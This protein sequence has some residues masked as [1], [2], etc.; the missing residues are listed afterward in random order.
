[1][2]TELKTIRILE[3]NGNVSN[4]DAWNEKFGAKAKKRGYK[5]KKLLLGKETV[6]T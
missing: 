4:W 5:Y 3:F 2:T 6:P 1:M